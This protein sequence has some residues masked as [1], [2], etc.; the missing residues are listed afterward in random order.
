MEFA[1]KIVVITGANRGIGLAVT[2]QFLQQGATVIGLVRNRES[3]PQEEWRDGLQLI[4]CD[5]TRE[6]S[7]VQAVKELRG[8]TGKVD[9]LV[10]NAGVVGTGSFAM[11]PMKEVR[12]IFEVNV[13]GTM[14]FTQ[15]ILRFMLKEGGSIINL[16]S[17]HDSMYEPGISIYAAT[18]A[19]ISSWTRTLARELGDYKIRVNAVCPG[20]TDTDMVASADP[21]AIEKMMETQI[22]K[23]L[24]KP[25]EIAT[26]ILFLA[27]EKS[28]FMTGSLLRMDG[29]H[30]V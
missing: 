13:F 3:F 10:N 28:G 7:I 17:M 20:N 16:S 30:Y 9:I 8:Y 23:R 2:K 19:V 11:M 12:R 25:E 26:A 29:G 15:R 24:G 1:N 22:M 6:E 18:K 21:Q 5:L 14:A 27:S 4:E